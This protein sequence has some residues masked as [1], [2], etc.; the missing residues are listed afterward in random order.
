VCVCRAVGSKG[1]EGR[2][3]RVIFPFM[4]FGSNTPQVDNSLD[5][6]SEWKLSYEY[7]IITFFFNK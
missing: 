4:I 3:V 5:S 1:C 6:I 7:G 2:G